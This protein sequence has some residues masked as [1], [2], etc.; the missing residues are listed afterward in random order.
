MEEHDFHERIV[1]NAEQNDTKENTS[2]ENEEEEI[3]RRMVEWNYTNV[4]PRYIPKDED[5]LR[6]PG[7]QWICP[8]QPTS[9]DDIGNNHTYINSR[10][11]AWSTMDFS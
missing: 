4:P 2:D 11:T 9:Q 7:L 3:E 8:N 6:I 1:S 5:R 10:N